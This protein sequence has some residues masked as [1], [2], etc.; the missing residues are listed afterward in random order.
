MK[1]SIEGF[2]QEYATKLRKTIDKKGKLVEIKIDCTDLVILRWFVDFYPNM[3]KI[4]VDD[5]QYAWL[6]HKKLLEDLPLIDISKGAFI[7]R[8]Q[9]LVEFK[10]LDYRFVKEGGTFSLYTFGEEYINLISKEGNSSNIYGVSG[11]TDTGVQ[12]Q[13]DTKDNNINNTSINNNILCVF[14]FWNKSNIINHREITP[15]IQKAIEK[16]LKLYTLQDVEK[17]I[18]RY[19]QIVNDKTYY[20]NYKWTLQQFLS[21]KEGMPEFMDDGGKWLNYCEFK[22]KGK[23]VSNFTERN[24]KESDINVLSDLDNLDIV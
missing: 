7:E 16:A 8:M 11:Q 17:C 2:S 5:K 24:Y 4:I 19:S 20:F 6:T 9:K 21:R 22:K 13:T 3:K 10:I 14:D 12:V 18:T 15:I 1:F 23:N